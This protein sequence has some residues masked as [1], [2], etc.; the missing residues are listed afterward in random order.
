MSLLLTGA[1]TLT[2]AGTEM[3][4]LEIYTGESY[5]LPFAFTD[6]DG[7]PIDCTGWTV[8]A[9]AKW[10]TCTITYANDTNINV[11]N[12]VFDNP[13][14]GAGASANLTATFTSTSTG[15]GYVY[16]PVEITGGFGT[17][18][19]PIVALT[20]TNST[21]VILTVGV[22]RTDPVS[23]KIDYNREPLGIIVRYQ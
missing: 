5:T 7:D 16:V 12:L 9:S 23:G 8:N 3:Q 22:T 10:Y 13:Q 14:P 15:I 21:L 18:P 6:I 2:I 20:A 19:S 1:K 4:C 17:P 11:S